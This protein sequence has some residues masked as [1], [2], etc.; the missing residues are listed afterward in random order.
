MQNVFSFVAAI[1]RARVTMESVIMSVVITR[2][3][4]VLK[5]SLAVKLTSK[6]GINLHQ[7]KS[8]QI[9]AMQ[10]HTANLHLLW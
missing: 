7:R 8:Q 5:N 2:R 3:T 1:V 6:K 10:N 4:H 9:Y